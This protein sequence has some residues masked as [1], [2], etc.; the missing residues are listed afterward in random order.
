MSRQETVASDAPLW[1]EKPELD[2]LISVLK[3]EGYTVVGPAIEQGAIVYTEI[4]SASRL[5]IGWS[6]QQQPGTYRLRRTENDSY[7]EFNVGPHSWK[8]FF[9]PPRLTVEQ[10]Q[11][12]DGQWQFSRPEPTSVRYALLGVRACEL[13]AIRVQDRVMMEGPY[14]DREY[15]ARRQSALIIAV[16]CT[17]AA[18]TCFC[19]SMETG[20]R[21][22]SGFDLALTETESGFV[23]EVGSEAGRNIIER[24]NHRQASPEALDAAD[25]LRQRAE[26][27]I[28]K[29]LNTEGIRRS[30]VTEP[31]SSSLGQGGVEMFVLCELHDGLPDLF[32]FVGR[33]RIRPDR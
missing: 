21:C 26:D 7:F 4:E 6:D 19:T 32:L 25:R 9:F 31:R 33:R 20:P 11:R 5:P 27:Q 13:A 2:Q 18:E 16:N 8:Q 24:L 23:V 17:V 28:T 29:H 10:A 22:R 12:R 1:M 15:A 3:S 14:V 30:A